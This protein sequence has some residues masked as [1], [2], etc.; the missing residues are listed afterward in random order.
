MSSLIT[1]SCNGDG[2]KG[3]IDSLPPEVGERQG[4]F[5][6]GFIGGGRV[7][8]VGGGVSRSYNLKFEPE[9][10]EFDR[11]G[12]RNSGSGGGPGFVERG[13]NGGGR[14]RWLFH[15]T[16]KKVSGKRE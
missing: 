11:G 5:S 13:R 2:S 14:R 4:D 8:Y 6:G 7:G 1:G 3:V 15:G 9:K 12:S 10:G 16:V